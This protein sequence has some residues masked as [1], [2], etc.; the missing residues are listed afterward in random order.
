MKVNVIGRI[1]VFDKVSEDAPSYRPTFKEQIGAELAEIAVFKT[2]ASFELGDTLELQQDVYRHNGSPQHKRDFPAVSGTWSGYDIDK[3]NG[4]KVSEAF[5]YASESFNFKNLNEPWPQVENE[6]PDMYPDMVADRFRIGTPS[7]PIFGTGEDFF[8][9]DNEPLAFSVVSGQWYGYMMDRF[10]CKEAKRHLSDVTNLSENLLFVSD[11][12]DMTELEK[13]WARINKG[14]NLDIDSDL[15]AE[16]FSVETLDSSFTHAGL[17]NGEANIHPHFNENGQLD[18]ILFDFEQKYEYHAGFYQYDVISVSDKEHSVGG[19]YELTLDILNAHMAKTDAENFIVRDNT[20]GYF[21]TLSKD[22]S[23][24]TFIQEFKEFAVKGNAVDM[25]VGVIIGGAFGKIVSSIVDDIIMPPIGWLIG[26]V[27]FS[28][29]KIEL[30]AVKLPGIEEMQSVSIN[31]G[32]FLQT[33]LDFL[34]IAFCVFLM[35][36]GI[37]NL[38]KKKKAEPEQPAPTPEPSN[39]EKLLSEIRDLLKQK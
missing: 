2:T 7:E 37:N 3:Y 10:N 4:K 6:N 32:N 34:I 33:V 29:L 5:V 13:P 36:K 25:A 21:E 1:A 8:T 9:W 35:V 17:N 30:P 18:A 12:F 39:E 20:T 14:Q 27:K 22:T 11:S 24:D 23:L 26:G 19:L 16:E 31:Y 15:Y 28:D 38:S